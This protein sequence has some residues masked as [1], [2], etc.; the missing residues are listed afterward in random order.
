MSSNK[1]GNIFD[2][3]RPENPYEDRDDVADVPQKATAAQLAARKIKTAKARRPAGATSGLSQSANFGAPQQNAFGFGASTSAPTNNGANGFGGNNAFGGGATN[4]F[5]PAQSA[6]PSNN[7]AASSFPAFGGS[8]QG[9]GFNPTP[10]SAAGFNFTAGGANPFATANS[11][12]A[13]NGSTPAPAFGGSNPFGG[14]GQ[15]NTTSA[16]SSGGMFGATSSAPTGGMFGTSS[17]A[18][19]SGGMFGT[20]TAA[21]S[22]GMFG[23]SSAA[24][25][26]GM[27]GTSSAAPG[28]ITAAPASTPF[29]FGAAATTASNTTSTP[30]TSGIFSGFGNSTQST[31]PSQPSTFGGF[32]ANAQKEDAPK[33][34]AVPQNNMFGG[35]GSNAQ[36]TEGLGTSAQGTPNATATATAPVSNLF[37]FGANAQK[38]DSTTN[39]FANLPTAENKSS[40]AAAPTSMFSSLKKPEESGSSLPAD[41]PK[42]NPS[43]F[44]IFGANKDTGAATPFSTPQPAKTTDV[45]KSQGGM[46][47]AAQPKTSSGLFSQT[48]QPESNNSSNLFQKPQSSFPP[49]STSASNP[50]ASLP[51][52]STDRPNLF[53]ASKEPS[54]SSP[55]PATSIF[56]EMPKVPKVHVP[57]DW[58]VPGAISDLTAQLQ[59]LNEKYRQQLSNLPPTADWSSVSLWHYQHAV[60]IKKKID[61]VKKQRAAG[62]GITGNESSLSTKRKVND[63]SHEVRDPSPSKRARATEASAG[64]TPQ[65]SASTPKLSAPATATSNMF[66]KAIGNKPS[67]PAPASSASLFAPKTAEKPA[68]EPSQPAASTTGFGFKPSIPATNGAETAAASSGFKPSFGASSTSTSGSTGFKPNFG[69]AP[70]G[71]FMAQFTKTA[72]TY[73][74]L[75]AERKKKAMDEDYDSDDETK[76]EWSAR[77]DKAEAERLAKEKEIAASTK[78]VLPGSTSGSTSPK[79]NPFTGLLKPKSGVSTPKA[80][81]PAPSTGSQSIF[82]ASNSQASSPNIFGHLSGP[83]S[84]N[85]EESDDDDGEQQDNTDSVEPPSPPKRS[86]DHKQQESS[87][88]G[89]LFSRITR[90]NDSEAEKENSGASS[91]FGQSNGT[92]TPSNKPFQFF[93][94]GAASKTAPPKTDTFAGDQTFKAGTPIKFGG[95]PATEKKDAAP[96][97]SFQPATPGAGEFSTTPAKPPPSSIF[98]FAPSTGGSS[99]FAPSGGNSVTSSVFSS[100]ANTPL[101][102]AGDTSAASAAE[103]DEDGGKQEQIDLTKLTED[104]LNTYDI[105]FHTEVVLA[106]HQEGEKGWT[107]IAKG[108]LWILKDKQ[109]GKCSVRVRI[110]SG[111]T[112]VNYQILPALPATVTGGSKKMVMATK[113]A[114]EGGLQSVLYAVK[115]PEIAQELAAKYTECVPKSQ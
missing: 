53:S 5:P 24:T 57:K 42:S 55:A 1:R 11:G 61:N 88:K 34:A 40:G 72:K 17:A 109:T 27:F 78:F 90:D 44:S 8:N 75:A 43:G 74:E 35:F 64:P 100:R 3:G 13:T 38:S 91:L 84:S 70:A 15:N 46:F 80:P 10:P 49:S 85:Q 54:Q 107:N 14:L 82:N 21:S 93:D 66:A 51:K 41:T 67:T 87:S 101:S 112:P 33:Q 48:F 95:A 113:P 106:K 56:N 30:A 63:D 104:E 81:S 22:G 102:E 94:F 96:K 59:M 89:S 31:A 12:S 25:S 52:P 92:T 39:P 16:A 108:P 9:T 7:F 20:S 76:E 97:F 103:D 29:T 26:G 115:T 73:E 50:F 2:Q 32:G 111:A 19:S 58:A 65:L 36:K 60:D 23:T 45:E 28:G 68:T 114:K 6:A 47:T 79:E 83:S 4:S 86:V 71:G 99:L 62:R 110:P 37:N 98:N 18:P 69:S 105:V 77:Y